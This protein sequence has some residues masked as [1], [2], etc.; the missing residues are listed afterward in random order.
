MKR[1]RASIEGGYVRK[2]LSLPALLVTEIQSI[3]K[4]GETLSLFITNAAER[5]LERETKRRA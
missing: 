3:L 1:T 5:E 4:P 2:T